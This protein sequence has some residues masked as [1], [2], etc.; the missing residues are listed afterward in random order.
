MSALKSF[1][2][3]S[4]SLCLAACASFVA[5]SAA[6][7]AEPAAK[8]LTS[9]KVMLSGY[10]DAA[11]GKELLQ[12]QYGLVI[13]KL[14]AQGKGFIGHEVEA[15]TNLCVAY[16]MSRQWSE[17][18]GACDAAISYA[19]LERRGIP[20]AE[21]VPY[22]DAIAAAYS[23]RAVLGWLENDMLAAESDL[24][25]AKSISPFS[26]PVVQNLTALSTTRGGESPAT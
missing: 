17:A 4:R 20:L 24:R 19:R 13:S 23:N 25:H 3:T 2:V 6:S 21:R 9:D 18:H 14:A 22:E 12:G 1:R 16:I 15:S 10:E 11:S 8:P 7:A 5:A 26:P